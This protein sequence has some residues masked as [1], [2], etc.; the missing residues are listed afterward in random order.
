MLI[1]KPN[2]IATQNEMNNISMQLVYSTQLSSS[3]YN[4]KKVQMALYELEVQGYRVNHTLADT[5]T[6]EYIEGFIDMYIS[7]KY[8]CN[9]KLRKETAM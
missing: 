7:K 3:W 1:A 4:W 2:S 5:H 9:N 6:Y 8:S